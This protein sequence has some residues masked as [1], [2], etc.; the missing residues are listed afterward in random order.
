MIRIEILIP[1]IDHEHTYQSAKVRLET[2]KK[3]ISTSGFYEIKKI[4]IHEINSIDLKTIVKVKISNTSEPYVYELLDVAN[5]VFNTNEKIFFYYYTLRGFSSTELQ[6]GINEE[7]VIINNVSRIKDS[8]LK[9]LKY[10]IQNI[11]I[12]KNEIIYQ[13][14]NYD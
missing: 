6:N 3:I 7:N 13:E 2:I 10:S 11:I 8:I 5:K 14:D 12:Y 4:Q 9:K 1:F